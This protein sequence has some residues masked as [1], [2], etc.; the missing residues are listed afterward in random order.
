MI[1]ENLHIAVPVWLG[2]LWWLPLALAATLALLILWR[3][4]ARAGWRILPL[5]LLLLAIYPPQWLVEEKVAT[6]PTVLI[7]QDLSASQQLNGQ[8]ERV[9][10]L[11]HNLHESLA[12]LG[13]VQIE[14]IIITDTADPAYTNI[15]QAYN[16]FTARVPIAQQAGIF[17]ISDGQIHDLPIKITQ[18]LPPWHVLLTGKTEGIDEHLQVI[19]APPYALE[20][21]PYT[22]TVKATQQTGMLEKS[23]S[24][25]R[26]PLNIT[27][28][29]GQIQT[30]T[31]MP[32]KEEKI[33]LNLHTT[34][35]QSLVLSIPT[36]ANDPVSFNNHAIIETTVQRTQLN[37][38]L[39]SGSPSLNT[40][41]WRDALKREPQVN[42][43][44][45]IILRDAVHGANED[46]KT[47]SLIPLPLDTLFDQ[48]LPEFDLV[49]LDNF[50]ATPNFLPRYEK[51]LVDY[52]KNG[53]GLLIV[54]GNE[55]I[56][57]KSLNNGVLAD[58]WPSKPTNVWLKQAFQPQPTA[59]GLSHSLTA[60]LDWPPISHAPSAWH[61]Q[62]SIVAN[63]D[64]YIWLKGVENAP[65][66]I[67]QETWDGR[68]AELASNELWRW[69][70]ANDEK[71]GPWFS[72]LQNLVAWL[73]HDPQMDNTQI[74]MAEIVHGNA[75]MLDITI[76]SQNNAKIDAVWQSPA[77]KY[78]QHLPLQSSAPH[79]WHAMMPLNQAG[80]YTVQ[81]KKKY[82]AYLYAPGESPERDQLMATA[83]IIKPVIQKTG[84]SIQIAPA[85][86]PALRWIP[87]G[88]HFSGV[89]W[90]GLRPGQASQVVGLYTKP[91]IPQW[92]LMFLIIAALALAWWR[93]GR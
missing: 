70:R 31:L 43:V 69:A 40:R 38:L 23:Q 11:A 32:D 90:W 52:V 21:E 45:F 14:E 89:G 79:R 36:A 7:I 57:E 41:L 61:G 30:F 28:P 46:P 48:K 82:A 54:D 68:V 84:G 63:D 81:T 87:I 72:L 6:P 66:L 88:Q 8:A 64:T 50:A 34:G 20:N 17:L 65:L 59:L 10:N 5:A 19:H 91:L 3:D 62:A 58:I 27:L 22:I 83:D 51:A 39:L 29:D 85:H 26:I 56:G 12:A 71:G 13:K 42:L 15:W 67:G 53:G 73:T 92:L 35:M 93:E 55:S 16:D 18:D 75:P 60:R 1:S 80:L 37:I 9:K 78:A 4:P 44:H 33:T 2:V 77:M 86:M 25:M 49:V 76:A 47:L 24:R 74:Q